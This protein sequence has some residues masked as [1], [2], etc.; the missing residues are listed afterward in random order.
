MEYSCSLHFCTLST[1]I[2]S[3][4]PCSQLAYRLIIAHNFTQLR[5]SVLLSPLPAAAYLGHSVLSLISISS[6]IFNFKIKDL[7]FIYSLIPLPVKCRNTSSRL[8][9]LKFTALISIPSRAA[10][11]IIAGILISARSIFNIT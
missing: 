7:F 5:W 9:F 10:S 3:L 6:R 2:N 11:S 8:G 4:C 1:D